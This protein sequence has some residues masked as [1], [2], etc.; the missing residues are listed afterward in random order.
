MLDNSA[1]Y[2][3]IALAKE[4]ESPENPEGLE[5]R[6]ALIPSDV[7]LLVQAGIKVYVE[8]G[9]G[10][11]VGF[12]DDEYLKHNAIM[13]TAEQIYVNKSLIIKFKGPALASVEQIREGCT[14]FCMTHVFLPS[15]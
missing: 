12:S 10:D 4:I 11:G 3:S 2:S 9:A 5:K 13:Q 8:C 1:R 6:V 7:G 14:L 15:Q